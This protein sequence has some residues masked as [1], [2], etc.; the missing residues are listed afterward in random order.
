MGAFYAWGWLVHARPDELARYSQH[1]WRALAIAGGLLAIVI[2]T[3]ARGA[4]AIDTPQHPA[5]LR[6]PAGPDLAIETP[7]PH[8]IA[9]SGLFTIAMIVFFL[10]IHVRYLSR[11]HRWIGFV[12]DASY[13]SYVVHL[14]VV[15][16]LQIVL[17]PVAIPGVIKYA[18]IL[19]A[20]MLVCLASYEVARRLRNMSRI[21][22][23]HR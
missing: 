10:G 20:A 16:A 22:A 23:P 15:V 11:P 5:L 13:W 14:P 21:S 9:A 12:S 1:A 19:A 3:L 17:A 2:H 8:A 7:P 6:G 18:A 4:G